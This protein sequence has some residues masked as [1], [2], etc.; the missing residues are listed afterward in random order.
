MSSRALLIGSGLDGLVG[1]QADITAMRGAL[2]LRGFEVETCVGDQATQ[3]GIITA[4]EG[5]IERTQPG[6][7]VVVYYSGHGGRVAPPAS[8]E[9]GPDPMDMQFIAPVDYHETTPGDFR[10]VTSVELSVLLGRLTERT[11]NA[12]VVLDCHAANMSRDESMRVKALPHRAPYEAISDRCTRRC[13]G[14]S[15]A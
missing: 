8:G 4:Y 15:R 9:P 12:V 6:D 3:D 13:P 10:A 7:A 5:L 14:T 11:D 1:V 2:T